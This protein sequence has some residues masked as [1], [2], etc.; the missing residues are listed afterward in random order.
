V[1]L[2]PDY[3]FAGLP[4]EIECDVRRTLCAHKFS[5]SQMV[6]FMRQNSKPRTLK[7]SEEPSL[8]ICDGIYYDNI[9]PFWWRIKPHFESF[10][11]YAFLGVLLV[12]IGK[13][14]SCMGSYIVYST[15]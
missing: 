15:D 8:G 9:L 3:C 1:Q 2:P 12:V 7:L 13:I 5:A 11:D 6:E 4:R 10:F 14:I